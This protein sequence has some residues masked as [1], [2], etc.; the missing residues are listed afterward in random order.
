LKA[1]FIRNNWDFFFGAATIAWGI[2]FL[3]YLGYWVY[4]PIFPNILDVWGL[5][6]VG[7]YLLARS[8]ERRS[9]SSASDASGTEVSR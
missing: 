4:F 1:K 7:S 6:L 9:P 5:V 3:R 2:G 8:L